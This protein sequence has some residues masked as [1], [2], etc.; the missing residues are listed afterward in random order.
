MDILDYTDK[1]SKL[2]GKWKD[3]EIHKDQV[4]IEDGILDPN[5][6]FDANNKNLK[7]LLVLKEAYGGNESWDLKELIRN[8]WRG[9]KYKIWWTVSYWLYGIQNGLKG[10]NAKLPDEQELYKECANYLLSAAVAN[11]KKSSGKSYS[12]SEDLKNYAQADKD[13]LLQ[14]IELINPDIILCGSTKQYLDEIGIVS[15][16]IEGITY[17]SKTKDDKI[18]IDYYHPANQYPEALCY[19]TLVHL[20]LKYHSI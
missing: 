1:E 16:P 15:S 2:F 17:F 14:Q 4:F 5:L 9:P 13:E 10:I 19:Y 6:W 3:K 11:I 8:D 12:E 20:A 7:I 18:L